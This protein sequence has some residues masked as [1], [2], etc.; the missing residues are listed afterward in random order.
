MDPE[1]HR[2]VDMAARALGMDITALVNLMISTELPTYEYLAAS[3]REPVAGALLRRWAHLNPDRSP[4]DFFL[5][6]WELRPKGM[7][8]VAKPQPVRFQ[9][10]KW[11][12]INEGGNDFTEVAPPE[13]LSDKLKELERRKRHAQK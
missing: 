1:V 2:R 6:L 3:S 8:S 5:D 12:A 13:S 4:V 10:G 7:V 11:Y 9:D